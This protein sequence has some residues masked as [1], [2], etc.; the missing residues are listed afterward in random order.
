[1]RLFRDNRGTEFATEGNASLRKNQ[2]TRD[3]V[4]SRREKDFGSAAMAAVAAPWRQTGM[5]SEAEGLFVNALVHRGL[6]GSG[7]IRNAIAHRAKIADV[8]GQGRNAQQSNCQKCH[9]GKARLFIHD[10]ISH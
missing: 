2:R 1:M 5:A 4:G 10:L 8:K 9:Q 6:D 7:V 3:T